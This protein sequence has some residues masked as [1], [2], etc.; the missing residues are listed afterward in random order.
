MPQ[1]TM[2]KDQWIALFET[3]GLDAATMQRWHQCFEA[4][5]PDQHQAFLEWLGIPAAE[6]RR[7]RA[8]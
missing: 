4:R 5:H 3:I 8:G 6:I 2:T 1:T 7:I